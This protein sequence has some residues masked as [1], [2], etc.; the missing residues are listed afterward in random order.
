M[1][2]C[3][4]PRDAAGSI[5]LPKDQLARV[6][7]EQRRGK[8]VTVVAGLDPK[9]TD[10]TAMAKK[11]RTSLGTGGTV[12]DGVIELQGDHRDK[13]VELLKAMGYPAKPAGG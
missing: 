3:K 2:A 6:R 13:L 11:L 4:C 8:F 1:P 5:K 10:V 12:K 9:A 7:R